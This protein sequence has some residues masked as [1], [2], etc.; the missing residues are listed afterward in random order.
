MKIPNNIIVTWKDSNIPSY[1]IANIKKLNPDKEILFFTDEDVVKF[2][3]EEYD[4]SYVDFFHSVKRGCS[5][6]DFFRYCLIYKEG[7]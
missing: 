3:S 6:A 7:G 5:K 2:I 4:S 1:V